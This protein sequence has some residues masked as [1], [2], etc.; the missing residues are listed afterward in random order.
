MQ[1]NTKININ[2]QLR[3]SL[4]DYI[5]NIKIIQ[6]D[7]YKVAVIDADSIIYATAVD[8]KQTDEQIEQYGN[9]IERSLDDVINEF[10]IYFTNILIN[11]GCIYYVALLTGGSHRYSLYPEYKANRKKLE[12]PKHLKELI[13]YCIDNWNFTKIEGFEADDL[14]NVA[15]NYFKN[16]R[17]STVLVH[18]DKDLN[19]IEGTHYNYKI[20]EFYEVDS[21]EASYNL[22]TQVIVGDFTDN[23]KGLKGKGKAFA[24]KLLLNLDDNMS[25]RSIVL[26]AYTDVLSEQIGINEFALNYNLVKLLDNIKDVETFIPTKIEEV[27]NFE[28]TLN[29]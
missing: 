23:I 21:S 7:N 14:V 13:N 26:D 25:M 29:I 19:Q 4:V 17:I 2:S 16:E 20:N 3:S 1:N 5:N 9:Q 24:Y 18:T 28:V 11:S 27:I 8:K 10:N 6:K 12:K 15:N 22:W